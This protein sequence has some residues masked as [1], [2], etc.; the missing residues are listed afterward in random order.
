M[1]DAQ[2]PGDES[3]GTDERKPIADYAGQMLPPIEYAIRCNVQTGP[4]APVARCAGL[5]L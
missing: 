1:R 2:S 4:L 5:F 3:G